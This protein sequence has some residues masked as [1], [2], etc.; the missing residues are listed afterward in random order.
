MKTQILKKSV[1][2]GIIF[3]I[4]TLVTPKIGM[5][6]S[7][8]SSNDFLTQH[9]AF[10]ALAETI[11]KK[12]ENDTLKL[13]YQLSLHAPEN[14]VMDWYTQQ[15]PNKT[16]AS[17]RFAKKF[18]IC[19]F[20]CDAPIYKDKKNPYLQ[21]KGMQKSME[22][23]VL[24]FLEKPPTQESEFWQHTQ[25][26]AV[27]KYLKEADEIAQKGYLCTSGDNYH[28]SFYTEIEARPS[29]LILSQINW[30]NAKSLDKENYCMRKLAFFIPFSTSKASEI[31]DFKSKF[32]GL[33][34]FSF[35]QMTISFED[36]ST[37]NHKMCSE[38][39]LN[40]IKKLAP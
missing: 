36:R 29:N 24:H 8:I 25:S 30:W 7:T 6:Q 9:Q 17:L 2:I 37:K 12:L 10:F 21:H 40:A 26:K 19:E 31:Q 32:G 18:S 34:T 38:E 3:F 20:W 16:Y 23:F 11:A 22:M 1:G 5:G 15:E 28:A 39:I 4:Y 13:T 33:N 14:V 27:Q 35:E